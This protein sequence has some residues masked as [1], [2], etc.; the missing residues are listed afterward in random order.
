MMD[1]V[2]KIKRKRRET[3]NFMAYMDL[4]DADQCDFNLIEGNLDLPYC[5]TFKL[6]HLSTRNL[7]EIDVK[8]MGST[9]NLFE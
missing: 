4:G 2:P 5:Q 6:K 1:L 3:I 9:K 7:R 8:N